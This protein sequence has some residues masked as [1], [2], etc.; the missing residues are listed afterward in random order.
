[1]NRPYI[2]NIHRKFSVGSGGTTAC[3]GKRIGP[4]LGSTWGF[5]PIIF[6]MRY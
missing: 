3:F 2:G 1:M 6:E 5:L 4:G